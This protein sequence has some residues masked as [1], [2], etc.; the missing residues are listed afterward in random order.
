MPGLRSAAPAAAPRT[1]GLGAASLTDA[2][3]QLATVSAYLTA[4]AA[5]NATAAQLAAAQTALVVAQA[6][7]QNA[8]GAQGTTLPPGTWISGTAVAAIATGTALVGG[9]AGYAL[10][11]ALKREQKK[12]KE[13]T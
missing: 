11:G 10:R 13:K 9:V 1:P 3:T 5:G 8:L 4:A 2:Q 12:L 7:V 6:D